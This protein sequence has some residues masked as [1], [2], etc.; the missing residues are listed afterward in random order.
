MAIL[1]SW[2]Q[3]FQKLSLPNRELLSS[4]RVLFVM[5]DSEGALWYATEGG[6]ICRDNG[7]QMEVFRAD[8]EHPDL[9][10]S[11]NVGCLA[12][13]GNY[14]IIGTFHGAY[15]L[16]RRDFSIRRLM[17][18]DDK[19]VDDILVTRGGKIFLTANRKIY[20]YNDKMLL[21]ATHASRWK[22]S[23]VYVSHIYE[24]RQ[25]RIWATQWDGGLLCL[26][27]Q[28]F[29]EAEWPFDNAPTDVSDDPSTGELWIG[30][31]GAGVVRY[32]PESGRITLEPRNLAG[33]TVIDMQLSADGKRLWAS[34]TQGLQC[35]GLG[36]QLES[37]PPYGNEPDATSTLNRLSLDHQ[38]RLLVAAG[39]QGAFVV[40]ENTPRLWYDGTIREGDT[41]WTFR[42]RQG[43]LA[44]TPTGEIRVNTNGQQLQPF[45]AK[46]R[47]A[48]GIWV[49]GGNTLYACTTDS[50]QPF[51][52][53]TSRPLALADD[54]KGRLWFSTG[55]VVQSLQ[56]STRQEE[57]PISL[58]DVS[59][60]AFT[61][62]GTLWLATI[63]GKV[64]KYQNEKLIADEYASNELGDAITA[65]SV[66]S[67]GRLLMVSDH[68]MRLYDPQKQTLSQQS[69]EE[70]G[71]YCIELRPTAPGKRWSQPADKELEPRL[72]DWMASWW[73]MCV[74]ALLL[75][76]LVWLIYNYYILRRQRTRFLK[77]L[78]EQS[79]QSEL[80]QP[81]ETS[82]ESSQQED[83][84]SA[85]SAK[86]EEKGSGQSEDKEKLKEP[87]PLPAKEEKK[88]VSPFLKKAIAQVEQHLSD[89]NYSVEELSRDLCMSRMTFYRKIQTSTGQ[90]PTEFIRSV[91]LQRAADML[92]HGHRNITEVSYA[93]G[94]SSVSYFSR[95]FRT[96]FG[97]APTQ[98]LA[99]WEARR[100]SGSTTTAASLS[101]NE[102]PS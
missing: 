68:Y 8:A 20:E 62:D 86:N 25:G 15:L 47:G 63:Y 9:L 94:F 97:V 82:S 55:K 39:S 19:R 89:E 92:R 48:S 79:V 71:V 27:N 1:P 26:K 84:A 58:P 85:Q 36:S 59:S 57:R 51:T 31:V 37:L 73:M 33:M 44:L 77:K 76:G 66:D 53:L 69:R 2:S 45:M 61:P 16:D 14:I 12:E 70:E 35:L 95:S 102:M 72:P 21:Q 64:Y 5:Q 42:E 13:Q 60:V 98:F 43:L 29:V 87:S 7:I 74:Y 78:N 54:G 11:N 38:G 3:P 52:T 96:M 65:L 30:T 32:N 23:D 101:P 41:I 81:M 6:G 90:K 34:T 88:G 49:A 80:L 4:E 100:E 18:V 24:D 50:L 17:E 56:L 67:L 93:T 28:T 10:G 83:E 99:D 40:A 22:G 75:L 46:R 91:R